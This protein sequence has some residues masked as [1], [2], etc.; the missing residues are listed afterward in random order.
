MTERQRLFCDYY[1]IC[2]DKK[3]AA[4][5]AGYGEK[6]AGVYGNR[7]LKNPLIR[8][9]VD[10]KLNKKVHRPIAGDEEVLQFLT[11]VLRGDEVENVRE[12]MKAAELLGKHLGCFGDN[13]QFSDD[14]E[15]IAFCNGDK[16]AN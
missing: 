3:E 2:G 9:A 13:P 1:V 4:L 6:C 5:A 12:R 7:L 11:R 8:Q 15:P 16:I 14:F 10:E